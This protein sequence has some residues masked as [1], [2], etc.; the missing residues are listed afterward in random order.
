M[1][2]GREIR[3]QSHSGRRRRVEDLLEDH[4]RAFPP[5]GQCAGRHFVQ[6]CAEREQIRAGIEFFGTN[7]LRR[8]VGDGS[9][10]LPGTRQVLFERSEISIPSDKMSSVSIGCPPIRCFSVTP[11]RYSIT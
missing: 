9:D 8:H 10:S 4:A 7:L 11:S 2:V 6:H 5:E 1:D 3:I